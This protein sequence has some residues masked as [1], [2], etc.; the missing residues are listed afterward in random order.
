MKV[1]RTQQERFLI[2]RRTMDIK[3]LQKEVMEFRDA[4]DREQYPNPK[5]LAISLSLR[6]RG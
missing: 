3:E 2:V 4:L 1:L 6:G 5:D